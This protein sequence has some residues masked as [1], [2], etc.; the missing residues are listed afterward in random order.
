MVVIRQLANLLLA[1]RQEATFKASFPVVLQ[2]LMVTPEGNQVLVAHQQEAAFKASF[3]VVL[4]SLVVTPEGNQVLVARQ[5]EA[6]F[7]A[8]VLVVLRS[9]LVVVRVVVRA[10]VARKLE[11]PE[12]KTPE[13]LEHFRSLQS[14]CSVIHPQR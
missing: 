9:L 5:Q 7:K 10:L 1:R 3:P 12:D 8:S 6:A 2:S 14:S 11:H 4:Q 13:G